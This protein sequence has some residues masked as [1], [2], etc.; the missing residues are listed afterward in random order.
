MR[1]KAWLLC[2]V[3]GCRSAPGPGVETADA[4]AGDR[5]SGTALWNFSVHASGLSEFEGRAAWASAV[6]PQDLSGKPSTIVAWMQGHVQAGALDLAC[7]RGIPSNTYY[8][9]VA[10]V[11]DADG[12]GDCSPNDRVVY[13]EEFYAIEGDVELS[14]PSASHWN[15]KGTDFCRYYFDLSR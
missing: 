12:S 14:G 10:V 8:P 2:L 13:F 15:W 11:V 9:S 1:K 6:E 5:C 7:L 3:A 4:L